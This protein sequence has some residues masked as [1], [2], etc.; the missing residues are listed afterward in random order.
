MIHSYI[1]YK[2]VCFKTC[3]LFFR[4][5]SVL[6]LLFSKSSLFLCIAGATILAQLSPAST[7][8]R[9]KVGSV[10]MCVGAGEKSH[11]ILRVKFQTVLQR[12]KRFQD[13]SYNVYGNLLSS[14]SCLLRCVLF[15]RCLHVFTLQVATFHGHSVKTTDDEPLFYPV[16]KS[17][18][19]Y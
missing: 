7:L 4:T 15:T 13:I 17:T 6:K 3:P 8:L 2:A 12:P 14:A 5:T 16:I 18:S 10:G 19:S 11:K 1:V 9:N